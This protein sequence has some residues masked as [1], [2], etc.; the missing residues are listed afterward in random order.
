MKAYH[1][2]CVR[3]TEEDLA[4]LRENYASMRARDIAAHLR[5]TQQAVCARAGLLGLESRQRAGAN[6]LVKDYFKVIDTPMKA[7]VLGLLAADG[8]ISRAGQLK[9]ELHSKDIEI[10]EAARDELAPDARIFFRVLGKS[11]MARFTIQNP[12]LQADLASLGVVSAKSLITEWPNGLPGA[13]MNS[14]VCGYYDGDGSL[15]TTGKW[16]RW[17][18]VSGNPPFLEEMQVRIQEH[19]GIWVGGPYE[20]RRHEHAWSIVKSGESVRALDE[21]IHRDVPGLTRKRLPPVQESD[22][23]A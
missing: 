15:G 8:N 2:G 10:V 22:K 6:S 3:W 11:P 5:R 7:W 20:D 23:A 17:A 19:T 12:G 9:L 18:V 13:F 16:L 4:Y 1:Y 14:F 21:W